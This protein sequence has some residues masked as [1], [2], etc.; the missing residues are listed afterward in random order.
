MT[1]VGRQRFQGTSGG[2]EGV[3]GL[4][5]FTHHGS[6]ATTHFWAYDGNGNVTALLHAPSSTPHAQYEYGPF[7]EPIRLTGPAANQ[8]PF[9]FSTKRTDNTTDL[10]LYEYRVYQSE[11]GRWCS[12]D[13]IG[14]KGFHVLH[15]YRPRLSVDGNVYI[16]VNNSA[17]DQVDLLGLCT[18]GCHRTGCVIRVLPAGYS[19]N[20]EEVVANLVQLYTSVEL[21]GL[22]YGAGVTAAAATCGL[23]EE[24]IAQGLKTCI[25]HTLTPPAEAIEKAAKNL[26]E[27]LGDHYG[28]VA[29]FKVRYEACEC[30]SWLGRLWTGEAGYWRELSGSKDW[31]QVSGDLPITGGF[32]SPEGALSAG[33][34]A[35]RKKQAHFIARNKMCC[36]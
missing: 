2:A 4:L 29:W 21:V 12:R 13:P 22:L 15:R 10:V 6:L 8:N 32:D 3:G 1:A 28:W 11:V 17:L 31:E 27:K 18:P 24:A 5:M 35:C 33:L 16:F 23:I 7:A 19:P 20:V 36:N 34:E 25:E 26:L 30:R 14:E 9:R